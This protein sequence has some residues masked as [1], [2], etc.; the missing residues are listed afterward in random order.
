MPR[1]Y[2]GATTQTYRKLYGYKKTIAWQKADDLA[3]MVHGRTARF[4]P[5]YY[6]LKD[7]MRGAAISVKSNIAE[8]YCRASLGD[9]IRFCEI[10]RGSLGELGSQ[11]QDC[12][13]WRL[14]TGDE[15]TDLLEQYGDTTFFLERLIT[16]LKKKQKTG[17]WDK[18]FGVKEA[19]VAYATED[20]DH[21]SELPEGI[22]EE[23]WGTWG[24]S[25]GPPSSPELP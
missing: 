15:L 13:R 3:W 18:S 8:G 21:P 20:A 5:G 10:A 2:Q 7:Q 24:N 1:A 23:L 22:S 25:E 19:G 9:Y 11:I 14:I 6:R 4:G 12:E 17:E 16:G